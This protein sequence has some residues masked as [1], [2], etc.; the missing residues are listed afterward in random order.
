MGDMT[1]LQKQEVAR[2][3]EAMGA[4][5]GRYAKR[6]SEKVISPLGTLSIWG[7]VLAVIAAGVMLFGIGMIFVDASEIAVD[8]GQIAVVARDTVNVRQSPSTSAVVVIKARSG[9]RFDITGTRGTWTRVRT[10]DGK[11][12]GWISTALLDTRTSKTMNFR[13]EMKGYFT[14][15]LIAMIVIFFALRMKKVPAE[16]PSAKTGNETL[17]VNNK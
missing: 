13:Y 4:I 16:M 5:V 10:H 14:L 17:L 3:A 2:G 6:K 8:S 9:E 11:I 7:K 15:A 12:A 1:V